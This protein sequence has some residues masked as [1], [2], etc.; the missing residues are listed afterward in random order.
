MLGDRCENE[1]LII[2]TYIDN[3]MKLPSLTSE[4]AIELRQIVD[5]I[6]C[7]RALKAMKQNTDS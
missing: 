1:R 7:N 3:I 6:K 5:T 4:N 2:S